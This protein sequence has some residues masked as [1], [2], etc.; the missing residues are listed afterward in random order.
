MANKILTATGKEQIDN[1]IKRLNGFRVVGSTLY[2]DELEEA[3]SNYNPDIVIVTNF[4]VGQES[5]IS[6]LL[7]IK[8]TRPEVRIVYLTGEI[9]LKNE[10]EMN[11]LNLLILAGIYDIVDAKRITLD[12]IDKSLRKE[13]NKDDIKHIIEAVEKISDNKSLKSGFEFI[14]PD[15]FE[16]QDDSIRN[17]LFVISSIKPGT[18]KSFISAN[19]ATAIAAY[20]EKNAKGERPK[21]GLIEG[22]LQNLSLGT[23]LQIES[24][25]RNIKT[26]MKKISEILTRDGKLV[27]TPNEIEEVNDFLK[28][29]FIPYYNVK[30]LK[31]LVGSH[32]KFEE[33]AEEIQDFH[34]SYLIDSMIDEFDVLIVDTNSA[35][36]H[37]T[38]YPLLHMAKSCYYILNLDFNNIRN[39]H[40]YKE[41]LVNIGISDKVKYIL[42]EDVRNDKTLGEDLIFTADHLNDSFKFEARIPVIPKTVF[43]N[44]LYEGRPIILDETGKYEDVRHEILKIANQIYPIKGFSDRNNKRNKKRNFI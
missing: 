17:N 36:T 33:I 26:A 3:V 7:K 2:K 39:N 8:T 12:M 30:N 31:A 19:I 6:T 38:T 20:G 24:D 14:A 21:V 43:L 34:Y 27:G 16:K 32:L 29:C 28:K 9:D 41:T 35:L 11:A 42:N 40:R 22:D 25:E 23:L 1:A 10:R 18:G 13:K 5:L 37:V 44:R 15:D 4:L